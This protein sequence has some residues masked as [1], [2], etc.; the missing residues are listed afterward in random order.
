[1]IY[2][3]DRIS[4]EAKIHVGVQY[5]IHEGLNNQI[6]LPFRPSSLHLLA[7]AAYLGFGAVSVF[8]PRFS[9]SSL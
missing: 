4:P 1:M 7:L 6:D 3:V 8:F 9:C 5:C 2:L